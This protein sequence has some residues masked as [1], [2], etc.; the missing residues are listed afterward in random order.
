MKTFLAAVN[1]KFIHTA[2]AVRSLSAFVKDRFEV[3][4]AEYTINNEPEKVVGHL[5]E[6]QA[7]IYGFS[8]YIFNVDFVRRLIRTLRLLRPDCIIFVG[9]PEVSYHCREF[10]VSEPAVDF[11]LSGEGEQTFSEFLSAVQSGDS[12]SALKKRLRETPIA[13]IHFLENGEYF[14]GQ[15]RAGICDLSVLPFPYTAAELI[16]LK[17]RI[18]YYEGSRGCPFHCSYCMSSVEGGVRAMPLERVFEDLNRF[19]SARVRQVKWVDRTFNFDRKR[20]LAIWKYLCQNDNGVTNFHFEISAW[21][22]DSESL[23]FLKTVRP[24]LFQFEVGVQ[25]TY[26]PTLSAISRSVSFERL[27]EVLSALSGTNIPVH[28]DLIAGLPFETYQRFGISFNDVLQLSPDCLQLG[29]LKMLHGAPIELQT[30]HGYVVNPEPPYEVLYNRYISYPQLQ[31]LKQI[32]ALL[33]WYY[34]SHLCPRE[35]LW[36]GQ[37]WFHQDYFSFFEQLSSFLSESGFFDVSHRPAE[38]FDVLYAFLSKHFGASAAEQVVGRAYF[39]YEKASVIPCWIQTIR[40]ER[41]ALVELLKQPEQF[42]DLLDPADRT[43]FL[44]MESKKWFRHAELVIYPAT[45]DFSEEKILYLYK[46]IKK[47]YH[48]I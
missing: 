35:I 43:R 37:K 44:Q 33:E 7:D 45:E 39:S 13:G 15:Q 6:Q 47:G 1:S 27:R 9:G 38:L 32:E 10:L 18:L 12:R 25:S 41:D 28:A 5:Y 2:L 23:D 21:L 48:I 19:L 8:V 46:D 14:C 42:L 3:S 16:Q 11:I 24:G 20:A 17:D 4:Y 31:K 22:L 36:I 29:F 40:I 26:E 30:Q 34:N